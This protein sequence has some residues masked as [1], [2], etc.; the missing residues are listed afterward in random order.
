MSRVVLTYK[1][2]EALPADG[3]RYEIHDG[4]LSVTPAPNPQ[5]QRVSA[6]LFVVLRRHVDER[7]LGEVL[8]ATIDVILAD[9]SIVQ[10]DIVF[11]DHSRR[12][13]ISQRGIE[14]P[15]TLAVEILSPSTTAIDRTTKRQ[16]YARYGVPYFWLVDP[17]ARMIEALVLEGGTYVLAVRA[18][19]PRPVGLPPFPDLGLVVESLWPATDPRGAY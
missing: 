2:Y 6:S 11:L 10:P 8:Y 1:D 19:G 4:E 7:G 17:E 5:H 14:G 15:P 16:L 9:A 13:A 3:R 12:S 18:S